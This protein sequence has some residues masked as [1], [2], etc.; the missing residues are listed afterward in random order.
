M[1]IR[2][3]AP[4]QLI[5]ALTDEEFAVVDVPE[6]PSDRLHRRLNA[7]LRPANPGKVA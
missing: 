7:Y 1:S 5:A 4:S 2:P 6:S 3:R